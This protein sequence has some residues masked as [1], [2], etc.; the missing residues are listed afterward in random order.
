MRCT[1]LAGLVLGVVGELSLEARGDVLR[2]PIPSTSRL[3][4]LG[5]GEDQL[6]AR[7][8]EKHTTG[9]SKQK[10]GKQGCQGFETNMID[11]SVGQA[12][13]G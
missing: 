12:R 8:K 7:S 10:T 5:L 11:Q 3:E 2:S 6:A 13:R 4:N 9:H 1:H